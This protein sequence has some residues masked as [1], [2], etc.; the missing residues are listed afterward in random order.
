[1]TTRRS[2]TYT[3]V[4]SQPLLLAIN[5]GS[6]SL[7]YAAFAAGPPVEPLVRGGVPMD[8]GE[9]AAIGHVL[10]DIGARIDL[11]LVKAVGHRFV[12]GGES[13]VAPQI[14]TPDLVAALR[15]LIALDPTHLPAE[16]AV[17]EVCQTRLPG[18]PQVACFDTAF[19]ASLPPVARTLPVPRKYAAA[20]IR[21][22]GFHG[23]SFAYLMEEL[24]RRAGPAAAHG[25]VVLAHIGA[26]VSLAAV[27][28]GRCQDTTMGFTPTGGV[29]MATRSGDLD[30]GVLIHLMRTLGLDSDALD[31]L[32]NREAGLLGVSGT[33]GDV[34]DLL[35]RSL[36][37]PH[38]AAA[39]DLFC[40][41]I[42]KAIGALAA[43]LGGLDTLVFAGGVGEHSDEVRRAVCDTLGFLGVRLDP[44]RNADHAD[45]LSPDG[46]AVAVWLIPT[47][48]E[49]MIAR[50]VARLVP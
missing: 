45:V 36:G 46:A 17:L 44:A 19:H 16:I 38:A 13:F 32:V 31:R 27:R 24:G 4:M 15:R 18:I 49:L 26:G 41:Q 47:N 7:K 42:R 35:A 28:D 25:R 22:Y 40:Y 50:E 48:E 37:D 8:A 3:G 20:G 14:V 11:G 21:R 23:L 43:V 1:M 33:T 39:I 12:H 9:A 34:R 30:P 29:M 6:S 2:D 10:D 5:A